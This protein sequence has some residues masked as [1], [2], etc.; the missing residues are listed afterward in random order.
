M[1]EIAEARKS[2]DKFDRDGDGFVT[3]EEFKQA[4]V[5]LGD[6]HYTVGLAEAVIGTRD[7]NGDG[8]LSFDEFYQQAK[9]V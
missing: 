9:D 6:E 8:V 7:A 2:F 5:E 4:M 3:A 1:A